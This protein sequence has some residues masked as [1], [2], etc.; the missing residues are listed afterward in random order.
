MKNQSISGRQ[1][2]AG[3]EKWVLL[4]GAGGGLGTNFN[5][6]KP[7]VRARWAVYFGSFMAVLCSKLSL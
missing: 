5:S 2:E 1:M 4:T 3:L 7:S 6:Q